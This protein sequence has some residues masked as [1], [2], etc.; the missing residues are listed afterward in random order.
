MST[1]WSLF[2][3][4]VSSSD[5]KG[6]TKNNTTKDTTTKN[7]IIENTTTK[8][9]IIENITTKNTNT[10][11]ASVL[12]T[13]LLP[14]P[15][16][17]IPIIEYCLRPKNI[18]KLLYNDTIS[19]S[20][21]VSHDNTNIAIALKTIVCDDQVVTLIPYSS[22]KHRCIITRSMILSKC[23]AG[24]YNAEILKVFLAAACYSF[25]YLQTFLIY[26]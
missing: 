5:A 26:K 8:N 3:R 10:I 4:C 12:A 25:E 21:I 11:A 17:V 20:L 24:Y 14:P 2:W 19:L 16:Q 6:T 15:R 7:A 23:K 9:T 13:V 22:G 18:R 1:I